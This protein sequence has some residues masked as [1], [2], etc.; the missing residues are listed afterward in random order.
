MGTC[1]RFRVSLIE[2]VLKKCLGQFE[3][4]IADHYIQY[5]ANGRRYPSFPKG[6]HGAKDPE[7]QRGHVKK[8]FRE[9]GVAEDCANRVLGTKLFGSDAA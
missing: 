7:I 3:K 6:P 4:K 1:G 2:K 5:T 9:L 8:L